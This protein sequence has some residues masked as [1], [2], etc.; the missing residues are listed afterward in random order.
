MDLIFSSKRIQFHSHKCIERHH[1]KIICCNSIGDIC[2]NCRMVRTDFFTS[3][4]QL[5]CVSRA[6]CWTIKKAIDSTMNAEPVF[7]NPIA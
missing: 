5:N 6:G 7:W 2:G 1:L 4:N 3:K